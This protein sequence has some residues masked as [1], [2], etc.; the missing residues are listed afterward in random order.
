MDEL[1]IC[2]ERPLLAEPGRPASIA[3][4]YAEKS[5]VLREGQAWPLLP[6]ESGSC[7]RGQQFVILCPLPQRLVHTRLPAGA[8]SLENG[9]NCRFHAQAD[10]YV[11]NVWGQ[12]PQP[13]IS[14]L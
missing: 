14:S 13:Y 3:G 1:V 9:Q 8:A 10:R 11:L 7:I 6:I 5:T 2:R 4:C 12:C